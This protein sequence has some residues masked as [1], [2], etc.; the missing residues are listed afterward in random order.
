MAGPEIVTLD[1]GEVMDPMIANNLKEAPKIGKAMFAKFVQDRIETCSK[2]L[3]DVIPRA[4]L[5]TVSNRPPVDLK[6]GGDKLGYAKTNAALITRLFLSLLGR[7]DGDMDE[8]FRH[9]N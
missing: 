5:C 7:P 2:P 6:K 8:F 9:E 1:T 3:S 4:K